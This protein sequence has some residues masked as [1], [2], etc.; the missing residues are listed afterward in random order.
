ME[1]NLE[2]KL[3]IISLFSGLL[4]NQKEKQQVEMNKMEIFYKHL[5]EIMK[6]CLKVKS[7]LLK[8]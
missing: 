4:K 3:N 1:G 5:L 7:I 8:R 2:A 6:M